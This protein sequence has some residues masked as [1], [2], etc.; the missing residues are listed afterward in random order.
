MS[1]SV[2]SLTLN[3]LRR[4]K[5]SIYNNG[6]ISNSQE[7]ASYCHLSVLIYRNHVSKKESLGK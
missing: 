1:I 7:Y 3:M 5:S 4:R 2:Q 6:S